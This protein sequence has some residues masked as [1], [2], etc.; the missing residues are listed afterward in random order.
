MSKPNYD[1]FITLYIMLN[2]M[3]TGH[4]IY[5]IRTMNARGADASNM[6]GMAMTVGVMAYTFM[7]AKQ[8]INDKKNNNK[9]NQR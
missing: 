3:A 2:G 5:L 9:D 4:T 6:L 8:C 1:V 7:R